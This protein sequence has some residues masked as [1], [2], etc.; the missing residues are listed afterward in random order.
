MS[1]CIFVASLPYSEKYIYIPP[2]YLLNSHH[3]PATV[4]RVIKHLIL[5]YQ[6]VEWR[7]RQLWIERTCSQRLNSLLQEFAH[8]V[9][10]LG[11]VFELRGISV[12]TAFPLYH[13]AITYYHI[14]PKGRNLFKLKRGMV[15][16]EYCF[17]YDSSS[18]DQGFSDHR[19]CLH[20]DREVSSRLWCCHQLLPVDVSLEGLIIRM[21][22]LLLFFL[23]FS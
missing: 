1:S 3:K 7:W 21:E 14:S 5:C 15:G 6:T 4:I 22:A 16:L 17:I 19:L 12:H 23:P 20:F 13:T 11:P 2:Y 8:R 18:N 10:A 9:Y